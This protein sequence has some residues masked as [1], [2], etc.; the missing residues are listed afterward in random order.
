MYYVN[1]FYTFYVFLTC[2][3]FKNYDNKDMEE[4]FFSR[5]EEL[6]KEKKKTQKDMVVHIGVSAQSFTNWKARNSI[7]SADIA[8][9]IAQFLNTSVEYLVTGE[10][11]KDNSKIIL[12]D[13]QELIDRYS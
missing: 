4:L 2:F 6:L 3:F 7:P 1:Y 10:E 13:L 11:K 5:I 9:K 8:V 12:S